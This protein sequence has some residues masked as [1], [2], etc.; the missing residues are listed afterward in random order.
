MKTSLIISTYNWPEALSLVLKSVLIQTVLVNEIIIADDGSSEATKLIIDK[1]RRSIQIPMIHIWHEDLGFR[2]TI[3]MNKAYS[4]AIGDYIIQVDGDIILHPKFIYDHINNAK[5][6]QFTHGGRVLVNAQTTLERLNNLSIYFNFFT[7]GLKNRLNAIYSPFLS[8]F[9]NF[10][11]TSINKTR[12]CNFA[13]WKKDFEMVNGYNEDMVGWGYEDT[14]LSV[15]LINNNIFKIRLKFIALTYHLN[16]II[17]EDDNND[18][19]LNIL[20]YTISNN[21][22]LCKNGIQRID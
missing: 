4:A 2:K 10:K 13:C 5:K 18:V 16:H 3:I 14:E 17:K 22:T 9:F 1:Y 8:S 11:S 6:N 15:R 7:Y 19:N 21:S 12:G 20:N